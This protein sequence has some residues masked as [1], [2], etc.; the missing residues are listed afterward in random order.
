MLSFLQILLFKK[1]VQS[2]FYNYVIN[3]FFLKFYGKETKKE[4]R[5]RFAKIII[6]RIDFY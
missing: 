6:R 3:Q 4:F 1:I 2:L 5:K